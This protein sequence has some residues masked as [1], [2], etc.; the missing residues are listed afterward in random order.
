MAQEE[1]KTD[2]PKSNGSNNH[3]SNGNGS[4][5][6]SNV[7]ATERRRQFF[8]SFEAKSLRSRSLLT[9]ISD[10]LTEICGSTAFL[11]FHIILFVS[12]ITLNTGLIPGAVP[13]DPFP[14]GLLTMVVSLEA[15][16]LSIFILVSQNRSSLVNT[17]REEVHLRV[18]LIAEEEI[19]KVLEVL[20]DIRKEVGIKKRDEELEEMLQRTDTGYIERLILTQIQNSRPS[21]AGRLVKDFPYLTAP[22]K[23]TA[24]VLNGGNGHTSSEKKA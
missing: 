15:I 17:L 23:K 7:Q 19:T 4:N 10:D 21:L 6:S 11:I 18:N 1:K 8:K 20:A 13:F 22:I 9:Q 3:G 16:F 14:F 2:I 24:E 5:T 12:W